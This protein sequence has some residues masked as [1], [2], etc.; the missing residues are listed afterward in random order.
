MHFKG[1]AIP[2]TYSPLL[3]SIIRVIQV[4]LAIG[5]T[6]MLRCLPGIVASHVRQNVGP[7]QGPGPYPIGPPLRARALF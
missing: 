5:K 2:E 1:E 3:S 7:P 4:A 6:T